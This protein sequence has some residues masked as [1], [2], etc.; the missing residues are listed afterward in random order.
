LS[1]VKFN[2]AAVKF[3]VKKDR[4]N[5]NKYN[6]LIQGAIRHGAIELEDLPGS[7]EYK[8]LFARCR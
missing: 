4:G 8:A 1:E 2:K 3:M 7:K 5:S 6:S